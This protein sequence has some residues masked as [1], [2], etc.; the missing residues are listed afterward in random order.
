VSDSNMILVSKSDYLQVVVRKG[1]PYRA[2]RSRSSLI[3]SLTRLIR[4][5]FDFVLDSY[6]NDL[7]TLS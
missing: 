2:G 3:P 5:V 6:P 4:F 1:C 7:N